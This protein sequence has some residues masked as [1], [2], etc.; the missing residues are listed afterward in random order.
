MRG[1]AVLRLPSGENEG[2]VN[3]VR[4]CGRICH[5]L[6]YLFGGWCY[7]LPRLR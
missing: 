3:R 1:A 7:R 6:P 2:G 5:R 4:H